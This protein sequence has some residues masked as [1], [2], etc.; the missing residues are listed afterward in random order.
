MQSV[1]RQRA[2]TAR[3]VRATSNVLSSLIANGKVGTKNLDVNQSP[4]L[5]HHHKLTQNDRN[6]WDAAYM[7]EHNGLVNIE[8]WEL[9]TE[10]QYNDMKHL[11]KGLL[12]TMAI[13]TIKR[14]EMEN[15]HVLNTE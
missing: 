5:L 10:D 12:P 3:S 11:Y 14:M 7:A 13:T 9:I 4:S 2:I 1:T 8:T 15:P 6:I